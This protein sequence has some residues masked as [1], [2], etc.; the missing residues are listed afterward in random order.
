MLQAISLSLSLLI[1]YFS[2]SHFPLSTSVQVAAEGVAFQDEWP[3]AIHLLGHIYSDDTLGYFY[4]LELG[5]LPVTVR[6]CCLENWPEVNG[7]GTM[8]AGTRLPVDLIGASKFKV[9]L[10]LFQASV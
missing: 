5:T 4:P 10:L 2:F 7:C 8:V 3:Y 1:S 6:G 9:L